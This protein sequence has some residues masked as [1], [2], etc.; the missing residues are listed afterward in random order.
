MVDTTELTEL[1]SALRAETEANSVSP[2]RV[3]YVLQQIVDSLPS[4]DQSGLTDDVTT[5]LATAR[6]ALTSAQGAQ[7]VAN[8]ASTLAG[9][10]E[11]AVAALTTLVDQLQTASDIETVYT[12]SI[13]TTDHSGSYYISVLTAV[14]CN[15]PTGRTFTVTYTSDVTLSRIATFFNEVTSPK[16][17]D[18]DPLN[19]TTYSKVFTATE[20]ITYIGAFISSSSAATVNIS[21]QVESDSDAMEEAI[22]ALQDSIEA[23]ET[24]MLASETLTWNYNNYYSTGSCHTVGEAAQTTTSS[25]TT[26]DCLKVDLTQSFRSIYFRCRGGSQYTYPYYFVDNDGLLLYIGTTTES[27]IEVT[28]TPDTMPSGAVALYINNYRSYYSEHTCVVTRSRFDVLS[29]NASKPL[30]GKTI[31]CFGDSITEFVDNDGKS[32]TDYLAEM[33]GATV[34]NVGIGGSHLTNNGTPSSSNMNGLHVPQMVDAW[35][36]QDFT[37]PDNGVIYRETQG[38]TH[39]AQQVARLKSIHPS[40]TDIVTIFAGTNDWNSGAVIG[41]PGDTETENNVYGALTFIAQTIQSAYPHITIYII[42]PCVR[43]IK[44]NN[45]FADSGWSDNYANQWSNLKLPEFCDGIVSVAKSLHLPYCNL[46]WDM[47]WNQ[48]NWLQIATDGTHPYN[49]FEAIGRKIAT[50]M[51]AQTE[52]D[53]TVPSHV[54]AITAA[55]ITSWNTKQDAL[56]SGVNIKTI[57]GVSVLGDGGLLVHDVVMGELMNSTTFHEG[58]YVGSS[59]T[60]MS[61]TWVYDVNSVTPSTEK[62]YVSV[63]TNMV[64]RWHGSAFVAITGGGS[65]TTDSVPTQN[66][67][68]PVESGGVYT[69]L[70]AKQDKM[71]VTT[72]I[73]NAGLSPNVVY[74]YG[75]TN[76][77]SVTL[78]TT[79]V[80]TSVAN[81]WR[82]TFVAQS[83]SCT[84]TLPANVELANEYDWDFTAGRYY[85]VSVMYVPAFVGTSFISDAAYVA[86]VVHCDLSTTSIDA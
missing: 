84:V 20:D 78:N 58:T 73:P 10:C 28:V 8:A 47:G 40:D 42:A 52:T 60:P 59:Q 12:G 30:V 57:N 54:K 15:I 2:E 6:Q 64:Y 22:D 55:D 74:H 68:N 24:D 32:Y 19:A 33:T 49:G 35:I 16:A 56:T 27:N 21:V 1:I 75:V 37:D 25:N 82:F 31:V 70:S 86:T 3:G 23:L 81:E 13:T 39:D 53:P 51:S 11:S 66:S 44:V 41:Q 14:S 4:L 80:D 36:D 72:T 5:A 71:A 18:K 29:D 79:G 48:S 67:T 34:Y 9:Q 77:V 69:A 26:F 61:P 45:T 76:S 62:L 7:N 63:T 17:D 83:S 46:Y 50:I 85:E 65:A 38:D 43:W